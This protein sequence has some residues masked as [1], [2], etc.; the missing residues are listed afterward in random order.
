[1][2]NI[3]AT[4]IGE[5]VELAT[6]GGDPRGRAAAVNL[7]EV[8]RALRRA[9]V[10]AAEA[11]AVATEAEHV[12]GDHLAALGLDPG[13]PPPDYG[14]SQDDANRIYTMAGGLPFVGAPDARH[15]EN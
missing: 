7:A 5:L 3:D 15:E 8:R 4:L 9:V 1:V 14:F 13:P 6:R 11:L 2:N 12:F 10:E